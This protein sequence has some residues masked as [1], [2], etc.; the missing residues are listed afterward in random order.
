MRYNFTAVERA[1]RA[2]HSIE[3]TKRK[4]IIARLVPVDSVAK[5]ELPDFIARARKILGG[6]KFEKTFA[7]YLAE[8]RGRY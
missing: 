6:K 3:I 8:E 1:L 2:G 7:E 5:P 4:R